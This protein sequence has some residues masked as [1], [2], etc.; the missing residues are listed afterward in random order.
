MKNTL[1]LTAV[2]LIGLFLFTFAFAQ[3]KEPAKEAPK[4]APTAK[5]AASAPKIVSPEMENEQSKEALKANAKQV[6]RTKEREA[7][8]DGSKEASKESL[9]EAAKESLKEAE[10]VALKDTAKSNGADKNDKTP[11]AKKEVASAKEATP[12]AESVKEKTTYVKVDPVKEAA[13]LREF[14]RARSYALGQRRIV[15]GG[16]GTASG[17]SKT[18]AQP[19][20]T[21]E[22]QLKIII[23]NQQQELEYLKK[24][25]ADMQFLKSTSPQ[26]GYSYP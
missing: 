4:P 19:K 10:K 15:Q 25:V 23:A 9:K 5:V 24:L 20:V 26:A 12:A 13:R 18:A 17:T 22:S 6:V 14:E 11:T 8:K 16:S 21:T 7:P 2:A 1:T 3:D